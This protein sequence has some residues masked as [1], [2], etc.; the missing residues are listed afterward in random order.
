MASVARYCCCGGC[1]SLSVTM[2]SVDASACA[3]CVV[4]GAGSPS[5]LINSI[6]V[7][8]D[9]VV[10]SVFEN[11]TFCNYSLTVNTSGADLDQHAGGGCAGAPTNIILNPFTIELRYNKITQKIVAV[12]V[13][14]S[15]FDSTFVIFDSSAPTDLSSPISNAMTCGGG[16]ASIGFGGVGIANGGTLTAS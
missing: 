4:P 16:S 13:K 10:P 5:Y 2:T 11:A 15:T 3:G 9:Y 7:D 1:G 8:G 12:T 6:S 14:G